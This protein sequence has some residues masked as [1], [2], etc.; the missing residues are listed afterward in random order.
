MD[1]RRE[2]EHQNAEMSEMVRSQVG[3]DRE[4]LASHANETQSG[5]WFVSL[6]GWLLFELALEFYVIF[7]WCFLC[8]LFFYPSYIRVYR[9]I[10]THPYS[11]CDWFLLVECF[12]ICRLKYL[13]CPCLPQVDL[14]DQ[15]A[16]VK[17]QVH[18]GDTTPL[19][20]EVQELRSDLA[21][22]NI[23]ITIREL[24]VI[25]FLRGLGDVW[26]VW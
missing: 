2:V 16:N 6:I 13:H 22:E 26:I 7:V 21:R 11:T 15:M 24:E 18:R 3:N 14:R 20:S 12:R 23:H 8:G 10:N 1:L 19:K 9:Y 4:I 17:G 25:E 5:I